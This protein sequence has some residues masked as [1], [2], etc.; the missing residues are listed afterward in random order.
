MPHLVSHAEM[1]TSL[2]GKK[3]PAATKK[4]VGG[5]RQYGRVVRSQSQPAWV[6]P[7]ALPVTGYV[8]LAKVLNFSEP[9][10]C[11]GCEDAYLQGAP[12]GV[13][14]LH[15]VCLGHAGLVDIRP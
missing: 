6:H 13:R 15:T 2:I 1:K 4:G 10:L 9:Y 8:T 14:D 5:E 12:G 7:L 3:K 11:K